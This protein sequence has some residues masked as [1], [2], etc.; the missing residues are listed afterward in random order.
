MCTTPVLTYRC[1]HAEPTNQVVQCTPAFQK[2]T[3][4]AIPTPKKIPQPEV[5]MCTQCTIRRET[6]R[7][8]A[9]KA[10]TLNRCERLGATEADIRGTRA[11][12]EQM[13][14]WAPRGSYY[15]ETGNRRERSGA[16]GADIGR[17]RPT[18]EQMGTLVPR[19]F[20]Y[21]ERGRSQ[22]RR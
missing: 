22:W 10:D 16:M 6:S 19:D 18:E 13:R 11:T 5:E 12:E 7:L 20:Y 2:R 4:C 14:S 17:T 1:N 9:R 3:Q 8:M 21:E 15:G